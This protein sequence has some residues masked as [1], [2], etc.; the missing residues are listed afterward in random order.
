MT[1][2]L[3]KKMASNSKN[4]KMFLKI[5]IKTGS[6]MGN[7]FLINMGKNRNRKSKRKK[8]RKMKKKWVR[9]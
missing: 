1:K 2:K 7:F 9:K 5:A 4:L 8:L 6:K 3:K